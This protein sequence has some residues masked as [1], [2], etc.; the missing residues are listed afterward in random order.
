MLAADDAPKNQLP[1]VPEA[2]MDRALIV[3]R[4]VAGLRARLVQ[5]APRQF[6]RHAVG[7]PS[8]R[9]RGIGGDISW[10]SDRLPR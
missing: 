4:G 2:E 1:E 3:G 9:Y 8:Y 6:L 7:Q 5:W 10:P